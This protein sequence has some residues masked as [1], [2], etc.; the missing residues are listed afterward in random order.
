MTAYQ[1]DS[2]LKFDLDR[3]KMMQ[4]EIKEAFSYLNSNP[5]VLS[6]SERDMVKSFQKYYK[7][8]KKL[9]EAQLR[10]LMDLRRYREQSDKHLY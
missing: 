9:S 8:H 7:E 2:S 4:T 6:L 3:T 1:Q 10:T 5:G